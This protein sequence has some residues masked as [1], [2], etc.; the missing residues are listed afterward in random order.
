MTRKI[1]W[2]I[3]SGL[4][5]L[6]LVMAA[7][8]PATVTQAP[9]PAPPAPL[10]PAAPPASVT[11][12][13]PPAAVQEKQA[14]AAQGNTVKLTLTKLDGTTVEKTTEKPKYGGTITLALTSDPPRWDAVV[15]ASSSNAHH[16]FSGNKM[17]TGDWLRGPAG[18]GERTWWESGSYETKTWRGGLAESYN[19]PDDSTIIF[20]LRKGVHYALDPNNE[21]SRLVGGR[22]FTAD[23]AATEYVREWINSPNSFV[24][25]TTLPGQRILSAKALDKYTLE[26]KVPPAFMGPLFMMTASQTWIGGCPPEVVKKYG[27]M[28]DW[29]RSVGTGPWI[30]KDYVPGSLITRVRNPN[31]FER[32]PLFPENQLPYADNLI[33]LIIP[34]ASTRQ[35]ALRTGKIDL[36]TAISWEDAD[37]FRKSNPSAQFIQKTP[38]AAL[39]IGGRMDKPGLP[40]QDIRVRKALSMAINRQELINTYYKG[41]AELFAYPYSKGINPQLFTPFEQLS[42]EAQEIFSYNPE[43]ARQLLK[44]AG[45]PNGF[46]T[47]IIT[48]PDNVDFLAIIKDYLSKIGVDMTLDV[49]DTNTVSTMT[50]GR[51][52]PEMVYGNTQENWATW[53]MH[54]L[55]STDAT[56]YSFFQADAK[57]LAVYDEVNKYLGKDDKKVEQLLKDFAP[58]FIENLVWGAVLP[59]PYVYDVYQPWLKNYNGEANVGYFDPN[60]TWRFRWVDQDLK[61]S[62]GH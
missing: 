9:Q 13:A 40:F 50:R 35:A 6:S 54:G 12:A 44:E 17:M 32:D 26:I 58:Y 18:T 47:S 61:K 49:R 59:L 11:P 62:L 7:C 38:N 57:A 31:Y 28:N 21:A 14:V 48:T 4:M 37:L 3:L 56:N 24:M 5:A 43:K 25:G 53:K 30:L 20:H 42:P 22:E 27:D 2:L 33:Q 34:D 46:K 39:A 15:F 41:H 1:L 10:A 23:D 8:G 51:T 55:F 45:Y 29:R 52:F 60:G 16:D 36:L 19:M